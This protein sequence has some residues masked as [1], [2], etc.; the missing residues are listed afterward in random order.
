MQFLFKLVVI[1]IL[2][3]SLLIGQYDVSIGTGSMWLRGDVSIL[4]GLGSVNSADITVDYQLKNQFYLGLSLGYG[5]AKG[6]EQ[7]RIWRGKGLGGGLLESIYDDYEDSIYAP[8]HS[9]NILSSSVGLSYKI[10]LAH[11]ILFIKAGFQFGFSKA[12]TFMNLY[13]AEGK[14]YE[15]PTGGFT[16]PGTPRYPPELF[17]DTYE[18]HMDNVGIFI[19]YSPKISIGFHVSAK[20]YMGVGYTFLVTNTDYLDGIAW[21]T[22]LNKSPSND[23]IHKAM[24][25]YTHRFGTFNW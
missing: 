15:L 9:T 13:D 1:F 12:K 17:D 11:D 18:T 2:F 23:V 5:N 8:Y 14:I 20:G 25:E 4:C 3:P 10:Y 16:G 7:Y 19:H 22:G 21:I 6:L 24:I